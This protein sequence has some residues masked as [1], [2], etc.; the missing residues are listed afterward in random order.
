GRTRRGH[1]LSYLLPPLARIRL[2]LL[3]RDRPPHSHRYHAVQHSDVRYPHRRPHH[4]PPGR[5]FPPHHRH[6]GFL[7]RHLV[8]DAHDRRHPPHPPRLHLP[9]RL[10]S[11][12]GAH[13]DGGLRRRHQRHQQRRPRNHPPH[14]R[15]PPRRKLPGGHAVELPH[16]RPLRHHALPLRVSRWVPRRR[17]PSRLQFRRRTPAANRRAE[18][19][20]RR[21]GQSQIGRA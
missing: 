20:S 10:G 13:A 2:C 19:R 21:N 5:R 12:P 1:R 3:R 8:Y 6:Q 14:L 18:D 16:P 11:L 15:P 9:H 17:R 7:R 4:S